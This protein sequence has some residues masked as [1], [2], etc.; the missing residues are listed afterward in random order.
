MGTTQ[1]QALVF[2]GLHD[3]AMTTNHSH[4]CFSQLGYCTSY[5]RSIQTMHTAQDNSMHNIMHTSYTVRIL[6]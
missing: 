3:L 6:L 5:E 2:T 4:L 1:V